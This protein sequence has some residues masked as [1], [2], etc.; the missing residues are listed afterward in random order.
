MN[1]KQNKSEGALNRRQPTSKVLSN[2]RARRI[3][4]LAADLADGGYHKIT[5]RH[6]E[7]GQVL[8][9]ELLQS[10]NPEA[11]DIHQLGTGWEGV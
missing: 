4:M 9:V 2:Q 1:I 10:S 8:E 7:Q 5:I 3:V 6:K 11:E